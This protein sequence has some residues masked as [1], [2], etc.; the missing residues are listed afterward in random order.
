MYVQNCKSV[1]VQVLYCH[2]QEPFNIFETFPLHKRFFIM[3]KGFRYLKCSSHY[4]PKYKGSKV[5]FL[6]LCQ[7][8]S[9][10]K[11]LEEQWFTFFLINLNIPIFTAKNLLCSRMFPWVWKKYQEKN[12][13][14]PASIKNWS[15]KG[16]LGN[17]KWFLCSIAAKILQTHE[18]RLIIIVIIFW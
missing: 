18:I 17:Q 5:V 10:N 6:K 14:K 3:R 11:R 1:Y 12:K 8:S 9:P 7:R 16:Y 15:L 2:P 4:T 13:R